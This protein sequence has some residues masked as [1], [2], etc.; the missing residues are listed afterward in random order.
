METKRRIFITLWLRARLFSLFR[1]RFVRWLVARIHCTTALIF[2]FTPLILNLAALIFHLASLVLHTTIRVFFLAAFVFDLA[3]LLLSRAPWLA[4]AGQ[5]RSY[6]SQH[7]DVLHKL[8]NECHFSF[9]DSRYSIRLF[10][11]RR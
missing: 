11:L 2:N 4:A 10:K 3:A 9:A 8:Y 1:F 5:K 7:G 6:Q